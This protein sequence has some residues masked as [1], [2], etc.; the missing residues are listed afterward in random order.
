MS[1][2]D[3]ETKFDDINS[4]LDEAVD[5]HD[6]DMLRKAYEDILRQGV[7]KDFWCETFYGSSDW[8]IR[9][10][11]DIKRVHIDNDGKTLLSISD[12]CLIQN[13]DLFE[14]LLQ[15]NVNMSTAE[16]C[17]EYLEYEGQIQK[18]RLINQKLQ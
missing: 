5:S 7:E 2:E 14:E 8:E 15:G 12:L 1:S 18:I 16:Q 10:A 6:E 11:A 17:I 13:I 9:I 4:R 3:Y